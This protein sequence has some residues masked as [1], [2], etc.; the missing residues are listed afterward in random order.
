MTVHIGTRRL[1]AIGGSIG[2]TLPKS[3][4]QARG[5]KA[6]DV[7]GLVFGDLVIIVKAQSQE[8]IVKENRRIC[9]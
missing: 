1:I 4:L 7:V 6:G 8:Q 5:W 2:V 3:F 9:E